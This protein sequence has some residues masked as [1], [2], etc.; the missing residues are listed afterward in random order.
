MLTQEYILNKSER[1]VTPYR[2][3][4][5]RTAGLR[6]AFSADFKRRFTELK[7]VIRETVVNR[8]VWFKGEKGRNV[9][10]N[11]PGWFKS[12]CIPVRPTESGSFYGVV[13]S[14]GG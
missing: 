6:N 8:I 10:V 14:S 7:K 11:S 1:K 13:T 5:T 12:I 3:D 4:P 2:H 9:P